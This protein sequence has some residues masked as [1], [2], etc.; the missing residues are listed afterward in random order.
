[1]ATLENL[2]RNVLIEFSS[3]QQTA[4]FVSYRT[5]SNSIASKDANL[6][7]ESTSFE[8]LLMRAAYVLYYNNLKNRSSFVH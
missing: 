4:S 5:Y 7:V 3:D 8:I 6:T 2:C 1:M